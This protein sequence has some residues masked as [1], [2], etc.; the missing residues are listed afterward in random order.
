M[1]GGTAAIV[2]A[3]KQVV[4][5]GVKLD[6]D[7]VLAATAGEE[8]DGCG[9]IRFISQ[10]A[11]DLPK[12]AGVIIP[13]PTNFHIVTAHRGILWLE[14]TTKGKSAHGSMPQEGINAITSMT[15][16]IDEL[17]KFKTTK[18]PKGC[19]M[20]I[21]TI[22]AGK[23]LNIVPDSCSLGVDIR[24]M[25]GQG[26]EIITNAFDEIFA[27]LKNADPNFAAD[28]KIIRHVD[29]M[30]TD[31]NSDFVRQFCTTVKIDK[32]ISV[33]FTTDGSHLTCLNVPI[34]IFG[35]GDGSLCHKPN[36]YIE[37]AD[38]QKAVEYYKNI[39]L[40]FLA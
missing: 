36:E 10:Q 24:L 6:G 2:T 19:S 39:I 9:V 29:G 12:L 18:L 35:P 8:V 11:E 7:I 23:A 28:L 20:S 22:S 13:E 3:I 26:R 21:N 15:K 33:G 17:E 38:V 27:R 25:Y 1:K 31:K 40:K 37:L 14:I 34:I 5:S 30:K 4:D 16:L 32:T